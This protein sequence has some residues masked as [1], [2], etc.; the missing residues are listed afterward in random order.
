MLTWGP[1][2]YFQKKFFSGLDHPLSNPE[3]LMHYD[4]EVSGFP[5]SHSGHLVLLQLKDQDYPG[6]KELEDWPT[7]D[8]PILKWAKAQ[9]GVVGFAHSG[10]G[11]GGQGDDAADAGDA[12]VR[13]HRRERVHRG[14]HA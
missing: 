10:L 3:H 6:T 11:P 14:R 8:L 1:G 5:S 13:R 7:W 4:L 9:G 2:Y 12:G